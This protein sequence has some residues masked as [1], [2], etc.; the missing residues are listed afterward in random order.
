MT[1]GS[2]MTGEV[3]KQDLKDLQAHIDKRFDSQSGKFKDLFDKIEAHGEDIVR[4][5]VQT[6]NLDKDVDSVS[7]RLSSILKAVWGLFAAMITAG[8]V[9]FVTTVLNLK[10]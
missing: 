9:A 4:L 6:E 8:V 2:D 7:E 3:T 1:E 10:S 5:K